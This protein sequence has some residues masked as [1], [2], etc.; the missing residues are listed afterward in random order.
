[1]RR[2]FELNVRIVEIALLAAVLLSGCASTATNAGGQG[3][4]MEDLA[5]LVPGT[6][7]TTDVQKLLG[8]PVRVT[9]FDRTQRDVWEYR[10]Y[11]DPMD[12]HHVAVQFSPDGIVREVLVLK[13]YSREPCGGS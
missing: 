11:V 8:S 3:P 6:S 1:M 4:A 7:T 12:E 9:R 13:D 10:R 2:A 5:K